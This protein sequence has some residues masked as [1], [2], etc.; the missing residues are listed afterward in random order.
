MENSLYSL[1]FYMGPEPRDHRDSFPT[2]LHRRVCPFLSGEL[3]SFKERAS[4]NVDDTMRDRSSWEK[5]L[6]F[7]VY[8]SLVHPLVAPILAVACR[9][10]AWLYKQREPVSGRTRLHGTLR[11]AGNCGCYSFLNTEAGC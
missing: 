1:M 3:R 9:Q 7:V 8:P 10:C 6:S 2:R 4:E 5:Y 11:C